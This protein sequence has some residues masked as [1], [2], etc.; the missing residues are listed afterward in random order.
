MDGLGGLGPRFFLYIM[1]SAVLAAGYRPG[2]N[3]QRGRLRSGHHEYRSQPILGH[4]PLCTRGIQYSASAGDGVFSWGSFVGGTRN[5]AVMTRLCQE[6]ARR[7]YVTATAS[8]RLG[9]SIGITNPLDAEFAKAA[10][11][12][13]QD[14]KAAVRFLRR[15]VVE[16]VTGQSGLNPLGL[17]PTGFLSGLFC[18]GHHGFACSVL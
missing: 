9:V 2:P 4:G 11:R 3:R 13:T 6:F 8:Y 18:R 5:D 10:I 1:G 12:A 7:G 15:S 14:A 17:I 16:G